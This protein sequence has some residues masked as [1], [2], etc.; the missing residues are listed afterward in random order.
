MPNYRR[1]RTEGATYFFTVVTYRRQ[2]ILIG[3]NIDILREVIQSVRA[4]HPIHIDAWVVLPDHMHCV[5][6]L[7]QDD[8]DFSKRWGLIKSG[9]TKRLGHPKN[10]PTNKSRVT[11]RE[12]NVWQ[13]R[14]W[15]HQ[16]HDD[17]DFETHVEYTHFNPVK[18][19]Y[20]NRVVDWPYSTFHRYVKESIVDE[21]W[22]GSA[23]EFDAI[24]K[25][26]E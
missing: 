12:S 22:G 11:Q 21:N 18:H 15:E 6:T 2:K 20:V 19:G 25:F 7:P 10:L 3:K 26:G 5:W 24:S 8:N 14:F 17:R 4:N 16:I 1:A 23:S 13:R 9:F